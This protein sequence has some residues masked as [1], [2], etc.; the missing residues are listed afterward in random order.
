MKFKDIKKFKQD[1]QWECDYSIDS[2]VGEIERF[3]D[4]HE[5]ELN[6]DFQRGHVWTEEQQINF[7]EFILKGGKTGRVVY[8]NHPGWMSDWRTGEAGFVCVD[9]LQR[10]TAFRRFINNE[11]PIFGHFYS[12]FEDKPRN[13]TI[14]LNINNLQTREEVLTWYLEM[15]EGG[16]PHSKAELDKVRKLLEVTI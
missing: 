8:L 7:I 6:P 1:G 5:L 4:E 15:N 9:G 12:E 10:I 2:L 14:R 11:I 16:T 3:E 13:I